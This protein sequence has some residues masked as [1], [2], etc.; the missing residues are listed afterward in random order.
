MDTEPKIE[1]EK[2]DSKP[3]STPLNTNSV[4]YSAIISKPEIDDWNLF[5]LPQ[6]NEESAD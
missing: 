2:V 6:F 1:E 4:T 3:D 5:D